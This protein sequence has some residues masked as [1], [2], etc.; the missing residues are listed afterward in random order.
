[1]KKEP[2][3]RIHM[4]PYF[5]KYISIRANGT[6]FTG[7]IILLTD[8]LV[9]LKNELQEHTHTIRLDKISAYTVIKEGGE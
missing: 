9:V 8:Y 4:F 7:K 2:L 6:F 3:L 1:M 5:N